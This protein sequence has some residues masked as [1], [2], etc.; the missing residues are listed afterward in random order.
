MCGLALGCFPPSGLRTSTKDV[1]LLDKEAAFSYCQL[2]TDADLMN[3]SCL[4]AESVSWAQGAG[5]V[6]FDRRRLAR[7]A[8]VAG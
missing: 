8:A 2:M 4:E 3:Q 5:C 7:R 6:G 1:Q